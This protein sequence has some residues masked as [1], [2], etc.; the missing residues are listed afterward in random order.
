MGSSTSYQNE[1]KLPSEQ[2]DK[3]FVC[4]CDNCLVCKNFLNLKQFSHFE[5]KLEFL[6]N[7]IELIVNETDEKIKSEING[8][9]VDKKGQVLNFNY[10]LIDFIV[11]NSFDHKII[12]NYLNL[13]WYSLI[14]K[15]D[16]VTLCNILWLI[17]IMQ[18]D[19]TIAKCDEYRYSY[20]FLSFSCVRNSCQMV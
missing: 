11:K 8:M 19:D 20:D 16:Q 5:L 17:A 18:C 14:E 2:N 10:N 13:D 6:Q 15:N 4:K 7:N 3:E 1:V 9:V 12:Y